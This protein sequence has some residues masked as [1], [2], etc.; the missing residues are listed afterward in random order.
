[1]KAPG[2]DSV[3]EGHPVPLSNLAFEA[4]SFAPQLAQ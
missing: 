3:K 4:K 2:S 1:L